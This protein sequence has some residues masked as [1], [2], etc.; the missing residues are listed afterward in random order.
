MTAFHLEAESGSQPDINLDLLL[1]DHFFLGP[2]GEDVEDFNVVGS[3]GEF[4][5]SGR[6]AGVGQILK[7]QPL[8]VEYE[9]SGSLCLKRRRIQGWN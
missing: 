6:L 2:T 5:V 8:F 3:R 1:D 4:E 9:V 7:Q